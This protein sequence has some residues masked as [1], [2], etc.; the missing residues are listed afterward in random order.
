MGSTAGQAGMDQLCPHRKACCHLLNGEGMSSVVK[1]I[2]GATMQCKGASHKDK[3][4]SNVNVTCHPQ[5]FFPLDPLEA[6]WP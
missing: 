4:L 5:E 1:P 3:W 6:T 2:M